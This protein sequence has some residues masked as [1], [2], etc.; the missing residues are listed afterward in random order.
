M[1]KGL[2]DLGVLKGMNSSRA[3]GINAMQQV[4]GYSGLLRDSTE[5]R[6]F[7]WT[8]D[9]GM[10]DIGTLGGWYSDIQAMNDKG[11]A[12]GKSL[13]AN[14]FEYHPFVYENGVMKDLGTL[15]GRF[16]SAL[17]INSR[18]EVVGAAYDSG[19]QARAFIYD[20]GAIRPLFPGDARQSQAVGINDRG[21]VIGSF[22]TIDSGFV[23]D[24]GVLTM[25]DQIPEVRAAGL[26]WLVPTAINDR[27]W[28]TG[29]ARRNGTGETAFVL[30]PK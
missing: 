27:G 4:V 15:G 20:G 14:N 11:A 16:G 25:L 18:G 3:N 9:T 17:A 28:I 7:I 1:D 30:I 6:A 21:T 10:I 23:Y 19:S 13:V 5:S 24:G 8:S 12:V 2:V 29:W 26:S 22:Q